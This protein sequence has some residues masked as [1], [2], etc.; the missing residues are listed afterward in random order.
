MFP[1]QA[2]TISTIARWDWPQRWP[3]LF[4]QLICFLDSGQPHLVHGTMRVLSGEENLVLFI[5][6]KFHDFLRILPKSVGLSTT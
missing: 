4:D 3:N 6:H 5:N 1:Q 2:Y